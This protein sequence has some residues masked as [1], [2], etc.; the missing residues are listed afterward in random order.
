MRL[1]PAVAA[2]ALAALLIVALAQ[3]GGPRTA[4]P[5]VLRA[6]SVRGGVR[7]LYPGAR[8]RLPVFLRNNRAFRIRVVSL[9]VR[10]GDAGAGCGRSYLRVGRFRHTLVLPPHGFL[11]T[12]LP[13]RM[14]ASAPDA[15]KSAVFHLKF[16]AGG[17]RA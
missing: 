17:S 16:A 9:K 3:S 8:T 10:I 6:I 2:F 1:L 15:C 12:H 14:L 5:R 13:V 7:L 4:V 11:T